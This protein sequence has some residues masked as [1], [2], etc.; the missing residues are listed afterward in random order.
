[1]V[2][3]LVEAGV[4]RTHAPRAVGGLEVDVLTFFEVVEELSRVNGSVG[5][6]AMINC[7]NFFSWYPQPISMT[8]AVR[9]SAHAVMLVFDAAGPPSVFEG[10]EIERCF[11]DIHTATQHSLIQ[12][13][14]YQP[15]GEYLFTRHL[16]DAPTD[17]PRRAI[18]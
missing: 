4:F 14:H 17:T 16:A 7:G 12:T 2:D 5:W 18:I 15:M 3:A 11:R 6:L 8:H 1:M 13:V 9:S 10:A